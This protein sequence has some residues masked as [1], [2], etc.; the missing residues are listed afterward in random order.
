M[1]PCW[2]Q[3]R[4]IQHP[5]CPFVC[6]LPP[7]TIHYHSNCTLTYFYYPIVFAACF[8]LFLLLH[9]QEKHSFL[10][11]L[12]PYQLTGQNKRKMLSKQNALWKYYS[13]IS[14]GKKRLDNKN[15]EQTTSWS[16]YFTHIRCTLYPAWWLWPFVANDPKYA[17]IYH[18]HI[19]EYND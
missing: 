2:C 14:F 9:L 5:H 15:R 6:F 18:L 16:Q 1:T 7:F 12:L 4:S 8:H 3:H 19:I 13:N 10:I 17:K 11:H